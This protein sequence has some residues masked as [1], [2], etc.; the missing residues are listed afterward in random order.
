MLCEQVKTDKKV[1]DQREREEERKREGG[2]GRD[3]LSDS[4]RPHLADSADSSPFPACKT[5]LRR[6]V[7]GCVFVC[8][9]ARAFVC[10][11]H[12]TAE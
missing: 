5:Q 12:V 4:Q 8:A 3:L 2:G 10:V 1:D 11:G 6:D 9:R 7:Q